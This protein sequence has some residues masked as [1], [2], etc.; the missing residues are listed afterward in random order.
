MTAALQRRYRLS[1]RISALIGPEF[2]HEKCNQPVY[3]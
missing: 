1:A 3:R 2:I